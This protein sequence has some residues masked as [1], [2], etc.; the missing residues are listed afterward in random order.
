MKTNYSVNCRLGGYQNWS[1]HFG[2]EKNALSLPGIE[3]KLLDHTTL[4]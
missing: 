2:E 3:P 4:A 1:G